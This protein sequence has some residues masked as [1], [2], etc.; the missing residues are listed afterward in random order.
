LTS[1]HKSTQPCLPHYIDSQKYC[2]QEFPLGENE[3]S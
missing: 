2:S 1:D 3:E